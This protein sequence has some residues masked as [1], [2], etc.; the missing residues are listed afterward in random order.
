MFLA[1]FQ[2]TNSAHNRWAIAFPTSML[3]GACM[4]FQ[5]NH[6]VKSPHLFVAFQV[7]ASLGSSLGVYV[8]NRVR[9]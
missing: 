2:H 6:A 1:T 9:R 4:Y 7:G 8:G 3:I 5:I